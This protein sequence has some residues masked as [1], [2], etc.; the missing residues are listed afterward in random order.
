MEGKEEPEGGP[1][2]WEAQA[3]RFFSPC[4]SSQNLRLDCKLNTGHIYK[5]KSSSESYNLQLSNES[6]NAMNGQELVNMRTD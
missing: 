4:F 3:V 6:R 5:I 1:E 2:K